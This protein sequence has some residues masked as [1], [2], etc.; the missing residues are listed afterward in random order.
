MNL[1]NNPMEK[2]QNSELGITIE[3]C[4]FSL[5]SYNNQKIV[6]IIDNNSKEII[7]QRT[8]TPRISTDLYLIFLEQYMKIENLTFAQV[9]QLLQEKNSNAFIAI[10]SYETITTNLEKYAFLVKMYQNANP[11][12]IKNRKIMLKE[13]LYENFENITANSFIKE[14]FEGIVENNKDYAEKTKNDKDL[15]LLSILDS[16]FKEFLRINSFNQGKSGAEPAF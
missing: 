6:E 11:E 3:D 2:K 10:N 15:K 8:P 7:V 9:K 14:I 13:I 16:K 5:K 12:I 1:Y 4:S